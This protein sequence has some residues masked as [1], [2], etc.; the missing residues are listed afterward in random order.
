MNIGIEFEN[1]CIA[2]LREI[3]FENV[4]GTSNNDYGADIVA[5]HKNIKYIF[6]CKYH[7]AKQGVKAV[8]QV[9][10]ARLLYSA[11]KCVVISHSGFSR[12]AYILAKS[13]L[14]SLI[15]EETLFAAT[16]IDSFVKEL[17]VGSFINHIKEHDY[18][19]I[20]EF[21]KAKEQYGRT[22]TLPELDKTLRYK[23]NHV[24]GNYLTFL[25]SI[26]EKPKRVKP[27][28][29]QLKA[30]YLRIRELLGKVPTANDIKANTHLP[31]NAFHQYPLSKLQEE[32]GDEPNVDRNITDEDLIKAYKDLAKELGHNP[33]GTE[34]DKQ[35]KYKSF[36]YGR[37]FGSLENFY[38]RP[39]IKAYELIR[40]IPSKEDFIVMF[41]FLTEIMQIKGIMQNDF[42]E[43]YKMMYRD[44]TKIVHRDKTVLS[45]EHIE[46]KFGGRRE[47]LD[48][49]TNNEAV[50]EF[51][52]SVKK[53]ITIFKER[54]K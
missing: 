7:Q 10:A 47:F 4:S 19:I 46:Y 12:Q 27:T 11:N 5:Y 37:R 42:E 8:Q 2:K 26:G 48:E 35:G 21:E 40:T 33:N 38:K 34:L 15:D 54:Y 13:D 53:A 23:I 43:L 51:A 17:S 14:V 20:K 9:M 22:P 3:G 29:E 25:S 16:D 6:Q 50:K 24:Y 36:L 45:C 32:C 52:D 28:D 49:Y 31:Y 39:E 30:E 1:R 41:T 44:R 18:D